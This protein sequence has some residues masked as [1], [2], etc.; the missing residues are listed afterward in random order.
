MYQVSE[1]HEGPCFL[2]P[3]VQEIVTLTKNGKPVDV[4]GRHLWMALQAKNS[5]PKKGKGKGK[6]KEQPQEQ[7]PEVAV[8]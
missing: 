4:C 3:E 1:R 6:G 5:K 7:A 2:C 8:E